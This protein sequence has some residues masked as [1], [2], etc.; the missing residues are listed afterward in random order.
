MADL[1]NGANEGSSLE[2][3][4]KLLD[5]DTGTATP[6]ST[7][8][9]TQGEQT[10]QPQEPNPQV[11]QTKAFAKRLAEEKEKIR[12]EERE[13]AAKEAGYDS[14]DAM[15]K[16]RA[17]Q[18]VEEAGLDPEA[19]QGVF[20]KL[21][22][23]K[24][25]E[26][27]RMRELEEY[28]NAKAMEWANNGLKEITELTNGK[29]TKLDQLEP[30]IFQSVKQGQSLADAYLSLHG[31]E[32]VEQLRHSQ[33]AAKSEGSTSHLGGS[34][35]TPTPTTTRSLTPE[36]AKIMAQFATYSPSMQTALD[37]G[38]IKIKK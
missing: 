7:E 4:Q 26:D 27:P 28:R 20:N 25:K 35:S 23:E 10:P 17:N 8:V 24:I 15:I 6:P 14:Y 13:A 31:R 33:Q 34:S 3:L 12:K 1:E 30:E 37:K 18:T 38:E 9:A 11:D 19:F 29:I 36:E 16:H 32:V 5:G 22:E 2:E 21:Y